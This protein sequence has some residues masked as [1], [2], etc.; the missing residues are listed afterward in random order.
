MP[1]CI[2]G[3]R[4][5]VNIV[6]FVNFRS[7]KN[8]EYCLVFKE[9]MTGQPVKKIDPDNSD[10]EWVRLSLKD[11]ENFYHLMKK[12]EPKLL[13][14]IRRM[15]NVGRQ[16]SEDILQDIFIKVYRKLAEY[17]HSFKFSSWIYRIAH[18]EIIDHY[19]KNKA[20]KKASRMNIDNKDVQQLLKLYSGQQDVE[21]RYISRENT[22]NIGRVLDQLPEKYREVLVLHYLEEKKYREISDILRKPP[23]TVATLINRAKS[24]FRQI[25][26]KN[27]GEI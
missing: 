4:V 24:K 12:Y 7:Q 1:F 21:S 10:K 19:H 6:R 20:W 16:E 8:T 26:E 22:E 14:Y 27:S 2:T 13:R 11:K 17:D 9:M 5:A 25:A 3:G 23:G 15:T 18:N